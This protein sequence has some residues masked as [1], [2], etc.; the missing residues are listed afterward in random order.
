MKYAQVKA[1]LF[2]HDGT[3]VDSENVHHQ[4]WCK[5]IGVALSDL[6]EDVYADNLVGMPTSGNAEFL[7]A[8]FQL[9]QS[10]EELV[11]KKLSLTKQ[12]LTTE[13]FPAMKDALQVMKWFYNAGYR[14]AIVSGAERC[15][16]DR[17]VQCNQFEEYVETIT[18]GDEVPRNKPAPDVYLKG[19][20]KMSLQAAQCI[21][22]EDTEHGLQAA[23][24]AGIECVAIPNV[25]TRNHNFSGAMAKLDSLTAFLNH[26]KLNSG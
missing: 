18:T 14:I 6:P 23:L 5:A 20:Q 8:Y 13:Y 10:P 17:S 2:D 1:I 4:L 15:M 7:K 3:L 24:A 19:M 22:V 26:F 12:F 21:A 9:R 25:H 11:A 16:V